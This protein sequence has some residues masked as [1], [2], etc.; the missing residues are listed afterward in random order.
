MQ[1]SSVAGTNGAVVRIKLV[2]LVYLGSLGTQMRRAYACGYTASCSL[3]TRMT[4]GAYP[5]RSQTE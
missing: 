3:T 4:S 1:R 2:G 5:E